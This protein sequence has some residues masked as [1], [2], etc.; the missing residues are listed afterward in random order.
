MGRGSRLVATIVD[1]ERLQR[2]LE[3]AGPNGWHF[4]VDDAGDGPDEFLSFVVPRI[5]VDLSESAEKAARVF[6]LRVDDGG[7]VRYIEIADWPKVLT[8]APHYGGTSLEAVA[9]GDPSRTYRFS[10][11]A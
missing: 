5:E 9:A 4:V 3:E 10:S 1:A 6:V 11:I 7:A 8:T 2:L